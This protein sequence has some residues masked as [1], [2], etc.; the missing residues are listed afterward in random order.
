MARK[1]VV[2][3]VVGG[4]VVLAAAVILI[5]SL[6]NPGG[7]ET[8]TVEP[9]AGSQGTATAPA[10]EE[11]T[12]SATEVPQ[13]PSEWP[14]PTPGTTEQ[15]EEPDPVETDIDEEASVEGIFSA[16]VSSVE[17]FSVD[18]DT[19]QPGELA[20]PAVRLVIDVVNDSNEAIDLSGAAVNLDYGSDHTP[21]AVVGDPTLTGLPGSIAAG[22]SASGEYSFT[23]PEDARDQVRVSLDVI[24]GEPQ[25]LFEGAL[26]EH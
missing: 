12:S 25:V 1:A 9:T 22:E 11:P 23:L 8:A 7:D 21:A 5:V 3:A 19:A 14:T 6:T 18:S 20:G 2:S 24:T 16:K 17:F 4:A 10:T 26:E 15:A 13:T